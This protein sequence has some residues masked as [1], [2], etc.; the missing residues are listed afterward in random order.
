VEVP[1]RPTARRLGI[2]AAAA[3]VLLGGALAA[4]VRQLEESKRT[5]AARVAVAH[6]RAAAAERARLRRDQRVLRAHVPAGANP[7][8]T[9]ERAITRDARERVARGELHGSIRGTRCE[10]S[11]ASSSRYPASRVY[12]CVT[13]DRASGA[14]GSGLS[15]G[16]SFVATI[17]ARRRLITWCK[18][19]L[20]AGIAQPGGTPD[21]AGHVRLSP[22]CAG[23]LAD[24]L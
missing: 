17:Y 21:Q 4:I 19:N 10:A 14:A 7:V 9:L 8:V 23:R 1:P 6:A 18:H 16:Y 3:L 20:Q 22:K 11:N 5:T 12:R 2:W 15:T 24:L 13:H